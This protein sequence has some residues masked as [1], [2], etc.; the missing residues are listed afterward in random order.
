MVGAQ[1][2]KLCGQKVQRE[3][4][5]LRGLDIRGDYPSNGLP[6][7]PEDGGIGRRLK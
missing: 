1:S 5:V 6:G 2:D 4:R 7:D 3:G